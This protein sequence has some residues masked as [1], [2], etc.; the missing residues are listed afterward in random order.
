MLL[1]ILTVTFHFCYKPTQISIEVKIGDCFYGFISFFVVVEKFECED[2]FKRDGD[3]QRQQSLTMLRQQASTGMMTSKLFNE[4][5]TNF[6]PNAESKLMADQIANTRHINN[7]SIANIANSTAISP[8]HGKPP[9]HP[10]LSAD[11]N[12]NNNNKLTPAGHGGL[13][14]NSLAVSASNVSSSH[15]IDDSTSNMSLAFNAYRPTRTP[16][17][18]IFLLLF[19][20]CYLFYFSIYVALKKKRFFNFLSFGVFNFIRFYFRCFFFM[21]FFVLAIVVVFQLSRNS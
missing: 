20:C 3:H 8:S 17:S 2:M 16:Q 4:N 21:L 5:L 7:L 19:F 10:T 11:T 1:F 14:P 9:F 6:D 13:K 15:M 12:N 18:S